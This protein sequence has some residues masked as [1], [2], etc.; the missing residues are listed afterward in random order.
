MVVER[1]SRNQG[2]GLVGSR[3][4]MQ[5][6]Q[7]IMSRVSTVIRLLRR[8]G[9]GVTFIRCY[10]ARRGLRLARYA[11][12]GAEIATAVFAFKMVT[13]ENGVQVPE[14]TMEE[15][16][17]YRLPIETIRDWIKWA[18]IAK[19]SPLLIYGL[20]ANVLTRTAGPLLWR[21]LFPMV[22]HTGVWFKFLF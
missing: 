1:S 3:Y 2:E 7:H 10:N 13:L 9:N 21:S 16:V 22:P 6:E 5:A 4:R 8:K 12:R 20:K 14:Y 11:F 19:I 17:A 18:A 15:L